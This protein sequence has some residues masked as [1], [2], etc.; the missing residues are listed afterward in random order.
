MCGFFMAIY[1]Q[2]FTKN[3]MYISF[4]IALEYDVN[5]RLEL[6]LNKNNTAMYDTWASALNI[7]WY[8]DVLYMTL[9]HIVVYNIL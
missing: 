1:L 8:N 5:N 6:G 9:C 4:Y 2:L 7:L 3:P